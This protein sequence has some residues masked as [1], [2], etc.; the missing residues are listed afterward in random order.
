MKR[1][2]ILQH[3]HKE[4]RIVRRD[5]LEKLG[6]YPEHFTFGTVKARLAMLKKAIDDEAPKRK[7]A[8]ILDTQVNLDS[9]GEGQALLDKLERD[10]GQKRKSINLLNKMLVWLLYSC[11]ECWSVEELEAA[12]YLD[13]A[14]IPIEPLAVKI[15]RSYHQAII[16][17]GP[18]FTLNPSLR[19][20]LQDNTDSGAKSTPA[21][22]QRLISLS[23][24][25]T[26][27]D[28]PTVKQFVW[29]LNDYISAGKF[30][31][32]KAL[33][34]GDINRV[35]VDA[36]QGHL[37]ITRL[38]F[39]LMNE[40]WDEQTD[41]LLFYAYTYFPNHLVELQK[42]APRISERD[43]KMIG[44]G[45]L[46]FLRDPYEFEQTHQDHGEG[47]WMDDDDLVA[48]VRFWLTEPQTY[49]QLPLKE[50][51]WID[52]VLS[53]GRLGFLRD[54]AIAIGKQWL[55][56]ARSPS[57][58]LY[59]WLDHFI[60]KNTNSSSR[61]NAS[62]EAAESTQ[63]AQPSDTAGAAAPASEYAEVTSGVNSDTRTEKLNG[64]GEADN[65]PTEEATESS[66]DPQSGGPIQSNQAAPGAET[67]S[68]R[69]DIERIE[70]ALA[71]ILDHAKISKN[72][73]YNIALGDTYSGAA[74]YSKGIE[75]FQRVSSE[76][77]ERHY[78]L[79]GLASSYNGLGDQDNAYQCAKDC[80]KIFRGRADQNTLDTKDKRIY[81]T[82]LE[83]FGDYFEDS[84]NRERALEFLGEAYRLK[85]EAHEMF[86]RLIK[87][88]CETSESQDEALHLLQ[89]W[90]ANTGGTDPANSL[91]EMAEKS[92]RQSYLLSMFREMKNEKL[93]D[94][95]NTLIEEALRIAG[96]NSESTAL[97]RLLYF[98]GVLHALNAD[99]DLRFKASTYWGKVLRVPLL[100][101]TE[102]DWTVSDIVNK[103]MTTL[104]RSAF[105][106]MRAQLLATA[107]LPEAQKKALQREMQDTFD[108]T[109]RECAVPLGRGANTVEKYMISLNSL[110]GFSEDA[111]QKCMDEM[112]FALEILSD[113]DPDNDKDGLNTLARVLCACDD[114][115]GALSAMSLLDREI[116]K[117][118][119]LSNPHSECPE[120][121]WDVR[122]RL[123]TGW[124]H[125]CDGCGKD[126]FSADVDGMWWCRFCPNFDLC[127]DCKNK[128]G[129]ETLR[130]ELCSPG[131]VDSFVQMHHSGYTDDDL[132]DGK[133]KIDW[134]YVDDGKG[135][136][137]RKGGRI[138]NL[139]DW[140]EELRLKWNLPRPQGDGSR[141]Q[142]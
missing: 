11:E 23:I 94:R 114:Q 5:V 7:M 135:G 111:R 65:T 22:E 50:R 34:Q 64:V 75:H 108:H 19:E 95:C 3:K 36:L 100:D 105:D 43:K 40:G 56:D 129:A 133:V 103:A 25:V 45:L 82:Y 134:E 104:M 67:T 28:E 77:N 59:C 35:G 76:S 26:E 51:R 48:G 9:A 93:R 113:A 63:E 1:L 140:V 44:E 88:H 98:Q 99:S 12:L 120:R 102:D 24:S 4:T 106:A 2:D 6:T 136:F 54:L 138:V 17:W 125:T 49:A 52:G 127:T 39:K 85:P 38:C 27:A 29:D 60:E 119:F 109:I 41:A 73:A 126:L 74:H 47:D 131:H 80:F 8:T 107:P 132:Q 86:W 16:P 53:Q 90:E 122:D 79:L 142:K 115:I 21:T 10:L 57:Y 101:E 66:S 141:A 97:A 91:L 110:L 62:Q 121:S 118:R 46:A 18:W 128:H 123:K 30:D 32:S 70:R 139:E 96:E 81:S 87:L 124:C 68:G 83:F 84:G 13:T 72:N 33:G 92:E 69:N 112:G 137:T 130:L 71:W 61:I 78:A 20:V 55:T 89:D 117:E 42:M 14:D 37:T 15:S 58:G 116:T 31:F